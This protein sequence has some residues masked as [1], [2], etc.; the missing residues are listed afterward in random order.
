MGYVLQEQLDYRKNSD[1]DIIFKDYKTWGFN[2]DGYDVYVYFNCVETS[3]V[4]DEKCLLNILSSRKFTTSKGKEMANIYAFDG[5][6]IIKVVLFSAVCKKV[7]PQIKMG[8]WYA[9]KLEKIDDRNNLT[10][11]DSYKLTS[12]SAII[13]VENYIE[14]KSLVKTNV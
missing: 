13:T 8:Q 12:D 5:R 11:I 7:Y 4:E 14:R 6:K 10:R 2:C 9:A 3:F 1:L